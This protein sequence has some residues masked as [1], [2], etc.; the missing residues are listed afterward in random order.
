MSDKDYKIKEVDGEKHL[1]EEGT[2]GDIDHGALHRDPLTG[3]LETTNLFGDNVSLKDTSGGLFG[4][5]E[6]FD[7]EKGNGEK[8]TMKRNHHIFGGDDYHYHGKE[9]Q[10]SN[11]HSRRNN[12][13]SSHYDR[14][15]DDY[16]G[17]YGGH[18]GSDLESR[19]NHSSSYSGYHSPYSEETHYM[20][21]GW[22][23]FL[24]ILDV[25]LM[26]I[27]FYCIYDVMLDTIYI[28][29]H[30]GVPRTMYP[31]WGWAVVIPS[32]LIIFIILFINE[33]R[34]LISL[35]TST[36]YFCCSCL[37]VGWEIFLKVLDVIAIVVTFEV[38]YFFEGITI[39]RY[40]ISHTSVMYFLGWDTIFKYHISNL[41]NIHTWLMI[42]PFALLVVIILFICEFDLLF[43]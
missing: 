27:T 10:S 41:P 16:N 33:V 29:K 7:V 9:E 31:G 2:F 17:G 1:V 32:I 15:E 37:P 4:H 21:L 38:M 8:G 43:S 40:E 28:L 6:K 12:R 14:D 20:P 23:I 24:K 42:S 34:G 25:A 19:H 13:E 39:F 11:E 30:L 36:S 3:N 5:D 35:S 18:S 26:P 22:R